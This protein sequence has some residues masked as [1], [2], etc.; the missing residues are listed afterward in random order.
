MHARVGLGALAP[1]RGQDE[2]LTV[3]PLDSL[4][5]AIDLTT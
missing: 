4:H 2:A 1:I 5:I 3:D